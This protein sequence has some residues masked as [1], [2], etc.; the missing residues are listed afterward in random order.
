ME[1][2]ALMY[3]LELSKAVRTSLEKT[4]E[5]LAVRP[6]V[7]ARS[8]LAVGQPIR[9]GDTPRRARP[10]FLPREGERCMY[11]IAV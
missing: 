8:G 9:G 3:P 6:T 2:V 1:T 11:T 10:G 7:P 4:R 5:Q